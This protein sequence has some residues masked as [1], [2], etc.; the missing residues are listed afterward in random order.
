MIYQT[1]KIIKSIIST[2]KLKT[3]NQC[4]LKIWLT[5]FCAIIFPFITERAEYHLKYYVTSVS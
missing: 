5:H 3:G 1:L 2:N 4:E